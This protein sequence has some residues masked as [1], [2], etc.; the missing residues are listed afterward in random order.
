MNGNRNKNVKK[1]D[2]LFC[3]GYFPAKK[4]HRQSVR[5]N[6]LHFVYTAYHNYCLGRLKTESPLVH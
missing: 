2:F 1:K 6:S 5:K 4:F 3:F